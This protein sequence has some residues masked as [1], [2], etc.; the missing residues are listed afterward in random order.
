[1]HGVYA[2]RRVVRARASRVTLCDGLAIF[3]NSPR[4]RDARLSE[5]RV[6]LILRHLGEPH[7]AA[8]AV[9]GNAKIGK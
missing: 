7:R 6:E 9:L 4:L 3:E 5:R 8:G 1:V 2:V